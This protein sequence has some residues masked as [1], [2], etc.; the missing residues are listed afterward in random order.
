MGQYYDED[1]EDIYIKFNVSVKTGILERDLKFKESKFGKNII[2]VKKELSFWDFILIQFKSYM[3]LL[4]LFLV[5]FSFVIWFYIN[6]FEYIVDA[7]IISIILIVN[8]FL[9]AFQNYKSEK[10]SIILS[11]LLENKALVLRDGKKQQIVSTELYPGDIVYLS[12]GDK[13]PADCRI[14]ECNSLR[15]D[16]SILTG[17]SIPSNKSASKLTSNQA[18][19]DRKNMLYMNTF[20]IKGEAVAIVVETGKNTQ[21]G[22]IAEKLFENSSKKVSFVNEIDE[23]SRVISYLAMILIVIVAVVLYLKGQS[24]LSIFLVS[25]ALL[26]GAIPEG[27]PTI[28][29]FLFS[30]YVHNLSEKN[31]LVKNMAL[32]ETLG[33]I[34]V[35]CTDK[36]GTLTQNNM[37]IKKFFSGN[38]VYENFLNLNKVNKDFFIKISAICNEAKEV[39][40]NLVG[41]PEDVALINFLNKNNI[42]ISEIKNSFKIISFQPFS[43]DTK[44]AEVTVTDS[45]KKYIFKKGAPEILLSSCK[46]YLDDNGKEVLLDNAN[47]KRIE[48]KFEEFGYEALRNIALSYSTDS[49]NYTF[50]GFVGIYDSPIENIQD[51]INTLYEAGID[52]KMI[53]GDNKITA[54]AIGKECGFKNI[55]AIDWNELEKLS[56]VEFEKAVK[57]CNIFSR[58]TPDF[59]YRIVSALQNQGHRVAITGDGVNDAP[60]LKKADVGIVMGRGSDIAKEAGDLILIDNNFSNLTIAIN[61]GRGI[62]LNV[63]KVVNYLLTANMVE[64]L[65]IFIA[66]FFGIIPFTPIQ[67]L[68]VNFVTDVAPAMCLGFDTFNPNIM[69]NKPTGK[70]EKILNK[71]IIYL[72]IFVSI[73]KVIFIF[74]LFLIAFKLTDSLVFAQTIAFT[75]LMLTHFIRIAVLRFDEKV[76]LFTNKYLLMTITGTF[77]IHL[78][79]L[80]TPLSEFF[81]ATTIPFFWWVYLF[82]TILLG[83]IIG[84][85]ITMFVN[86]IISTEKV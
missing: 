31:V 76:S 49:I 40:L 37:R 41:D 12:E 73:K 44:Y 75:W 5:F 86:Y 20:V 62:F 81:D 32:L 18:V 51:T 34:D 54:I 8:L 14:I 67:I 70:N 25:S 39:D 60:A 64:V 11:K 71:K 16:E 3:N 48:K 33:S 35:L 27:L 74:G 13:I 7:I 59:K 43:S 22:G 56:D 57:E 78:L 19:S 47:R 17:E 68:W 69:K 42:D 6:E 55:K 29:T 80:Y 72:T 15:V 28:V 9:G 24:L 30:K 10:I 65:T 61:D 85:F 45:L 83:I 53:T 46:Y 36:T 50:V 58:M 2:E 77:L 21:I 63:R 23:T 82:L 38:Q 84:R 26:I 4:L 52:V 66:S 79:I 1:I